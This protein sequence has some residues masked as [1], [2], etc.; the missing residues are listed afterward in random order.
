M[1]ITCNMFLWNIAQK[2]HKNYVWY[3]SH[4]V[5]RT[6]AAL[7]WIKSETQIAMIPGIR[8]LQSVSPLLS[9][10]IFYNYTT[11]QNNIFTFLYNRKVW[12]K[13]LFLIIYVC[14][15]RLWLCNFNKNNSNVIKVYIYMC[16][17]RKIWKFNV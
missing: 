14:Y 11:L 3:I 15:K 5:T 9:R 8:A 7:T 6:Y 16:F 4:E 12:K 13:N 10:H 2:N 1:H 17:K